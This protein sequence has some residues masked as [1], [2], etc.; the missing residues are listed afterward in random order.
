MP[1]TPLIMG[2][3]QTA[4]L[5]ALRTK[6]ATEP[7]VDMHGLS[8]RLKDPAN[9]RAHMNRMD[10]LTIEIPIGFL[11]T[12]SIEIGHPAGAAR[13]MSMS[14]PQ[15]GRTPTP[16]AVWMVAEELGFTGSIEQCT[17]WLEDLQRGPRKDDRAKAVNVVQLIAQVAEE[18]RA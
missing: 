17:V 11:V 10:E 15:R 13:H 6:A 14:S 4:Q 2:A 9:K 3:A 8:E 1:A 18:G 5:A 16:E 7:P 12:F